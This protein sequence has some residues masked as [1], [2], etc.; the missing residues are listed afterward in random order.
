[1]MAHNLCYST[2]L[3]KDD[4]KNYPPDAVEKAPGEDFYFVRKSTSKGVLPL[5]LEDLLSARKQAKSDM[6]KATDP[7]VIAVQ[8]GS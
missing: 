2:L 8:V 1:M 3:A 5:I 7:F 6:A 4:V